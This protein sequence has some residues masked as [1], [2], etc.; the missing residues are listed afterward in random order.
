MDNEC[1]SYLKE[2]IKKYDTDFQL[3]PPQMHRRNTAERAIRT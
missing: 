1:S 2:D 3:A